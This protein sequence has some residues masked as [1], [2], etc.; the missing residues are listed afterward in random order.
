MKSIRATR[1]SR[2]FSIKRTSL[3]TRGTLFVFSI[4]LSL[5]A[6]SG[7]E[8]PR[9]GPGEIVYV[10]DTDR[11]YFVEPGDRLI[12]RDGRPVT[13]MVTDPNGV[14]RLTPVVIPYKGV[15]LSNQKYTELATGG[16]E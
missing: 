16:K 11:I 12:D 8:S 14:I 13:V 2:S 10:P 3:A 1:S 9:P 5:F 6:L 4:S 15:V 7:C